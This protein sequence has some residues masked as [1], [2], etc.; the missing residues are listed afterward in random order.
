[1]PFCSRGALIEE[2][3]T[4]MVP[5]CPPS[6]L[7]ALF[8]PHPLCPFQLHSPCGSP[9]WIPEPS[10]SSR[11]QHAPSL[12][13]FG[14][15]SLSISMTRWWVPKS[16]LYPVGPP[17]HLAYS[18]LS[19]AAGED[20]T[21]IKGDPGCTEPSSFLGFLQGQRYKPFGLSCHGLALGEWKHHR[22]SLGD[23]RQRPRLGIA[24]MRGEGRPR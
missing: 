16:A 4:E 10:L 23:P 19:N 21:H 2:F 6:Q 5:F 20:A 12:P 14:V 7:S 17:Q 13:S 11:D 8:H 3:R 18:T 24:G 22:F 1:M 9:V 15:V